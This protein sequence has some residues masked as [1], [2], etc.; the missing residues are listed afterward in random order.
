MADKIWTIDSYINEDDK[1][2]SVTW[3]LTVYDEDNTVSTSG[4]A[5]YTKPI[6]LKNAD[7]II[8]ALGKYI[9]KESIERKLEATLLSLT[10]GEPVAEPEPEPVV[11]PIVEAV[12]E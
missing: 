5:E 4:V 3:R 12:V 2:T 10:G 1:I 6:P 11:E 7:K 9:D 8:E